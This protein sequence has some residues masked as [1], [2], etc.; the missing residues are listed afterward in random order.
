LNSTYLNTSII[1]GVVTGL[2]FGIH[3]IHVESVAWISERK[4]VLYAFFYL[5]SILF[6]LRYTSSQRQEFS[7]HLSIVTR[8]W[9]YSLCLIFFV[10]SLMSKPMAVTLPVVLIILDFYPLGR[11]NLKSALTSQRKVLIEKFPFLMLSLVSSVITVMAQQTGRTVVT[12]EL[13]PL[14]MRILVGIRA[15]GFYL[16]KMLWPANLYPFYPYPSKISLL[17]IEYM[18]S[19]MLV[20]SIT[21][22][23]I[24]SCKR[25]KVFLV[26][27]AYYV[28]TL[29]PVLGIIQVGGQAA[30]DRYTYLP[31]LGP[32]FLVGLGVTL[33][34]ERVGLKVSGLPKKKILLVVLLIPILS[35]LTIF[36]EKQIM[37]WKN[38]F[39][40]W[41]CIINKFPHIG[42]A[43]MCRGVAYAEKGQLDEAIQ[44]YNK[45]IILNPNFALSYKNR[46]TAYTKLGNYQQ[47]IEDYIMAVTLNPQDIGSYN[48]LG[49]IYGNLGRHQ[50]AINYY[51]RA[52]ILN[53]D[54]APSYIN[55]G[56]SYLQLG[57]YQKTLE[58]YSKAII[59]NPYSAIAY[60]NRAVVYEK[61][62]NFTQAIKDYD[63]A[64]ELNPEY[65]YAYSN[66]GSVYERLGNYQ[67]ALDNYNMAIKF[68]PLD[69]IIYYNRGMLY[70]KLGNN[71]QGVKD[72]QIAARLGDKQAQDYLK[73]EGIGW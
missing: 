58:D 51:N 6:Y 13:C 70:I 45:A 63:K 27:W 30:A 40:L 57:N 56:N 69:K 39:T 65:A 34:Y 23:C 14:W 26:A 15:L 9:W 22:F 59:I 33:I 28:V 19:L 53:P 49:L 21:T 64:I 61:M 32:F 4:D 50:L 71:Q 36:T 31:S 1:A 8:H 66:R 24:L 41:N 52:I 20:V 18:G 72:L 47:A 29:L 11:L 37:I 7:R 54:F 62:N 17:T 44:D 16:F 35:L 68:D 46:G 73:S 48:N 60:F 12:L 2:L 43:Y 38:S 42:E 3:P 10:L 55:R 5:L 25:H 67:E